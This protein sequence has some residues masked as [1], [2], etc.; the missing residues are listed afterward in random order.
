MMR[1]IRGNEEEESAYLSQVSTQ[2]FDLYSRSA[3]Q[4]I[5]TSIITLTYTFQTS[6]D[7]ENV[8]IFTHHM[9]LQSCLL[10]MFWS[11][12]IIKFSDMS[13]LT[14][15]TKYT[16]FDNFKLSA[17]DSHSQQSLETRVEHHH[18][19]THLRETLEWCER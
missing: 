14:G 18:L 12:L 11:N 8:D 3:C 15:S 9:P 13:I 10:S 1:N 2:V 17:L 19:R 5:I 6:L 4:I 16:L 7:M